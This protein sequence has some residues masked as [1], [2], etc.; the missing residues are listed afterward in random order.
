MV[1]EASQMILRFYLIEFPKIQLVGA[2][3]E[4]SHNK[5]P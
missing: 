2:S 1:L 4:P 3:P 5:A